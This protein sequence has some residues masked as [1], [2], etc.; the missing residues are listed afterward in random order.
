MQSLPIAFGEIAALEI[1]SIV[2]VLIKDRAEHTRRA[3]GSL[4]RNT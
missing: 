4:C 3:F 1:Y 2:V